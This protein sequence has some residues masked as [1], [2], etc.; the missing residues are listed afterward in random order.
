MKLAAAYSLAEL[1]KQDVPDSVMKAYGG[2]H[3]KFGPE[4]IIPKPFDYRVLLWEAPAVADAAMKTDVARIQIDIEEYKERLERRLGKSREV[5][6]MMINKAKRQPKRI[7]FPEG[8]SEKVLRAAHIIVDE[9]I[10]RPILL[11]KED[12]IRSLAKELDIDLN[13]IEIVHP[14][15]SAK[16]DAYAEQLFELRQRKGV[17]REEARQLMR[18]ANIYG[19][20]MVHAG[21]ADALVSGVTQ[22]YPD[23]IRPALQVVGMREDL[24]RV[25]GLYIMVVKNQ[26]YF[27]ADATV[28]IE[29]TAEELAEIALCAAE[30]AKRFDVEPKVAM[31]SFSN[32]GSTKHPLAEKVQKATELV[33]Q[34]DPHLIVDGEMQ[35]DTAVVPEIIEGTYPFSPLKGGANVLIFPDLQSGNIAYKLLAQLG[36]AEAIG[37]VLMGMNRPVH[38]LQRGCEVNDIVNM[39]AIAVVDAQELAWPKTRGAL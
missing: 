6:R 31:L 32:F 15:T 13:G 5:M 24:S 23:T 10:G 7:V 37:P 38:V 11:G 26:I 29:P 4:Y 27:F 35:A 3:L 1:A 18:S 22:H 2:E 8:Y 39:A 20:M 17:T 28:N 34:R 30:T 25:S 16:F 21:D 14:T 12:I 9:G 36:G 33:R 19:S